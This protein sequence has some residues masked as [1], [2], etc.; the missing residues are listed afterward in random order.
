MEELDLNKHLFSSCVKVVEVM[1]VFSE[2]IR[3]CRDCFNFLIPW[4]GMSKLF[5]FHFL[6]WAFINVQHGI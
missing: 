4:R 6:S 2:L 5:T 1:G 3:R